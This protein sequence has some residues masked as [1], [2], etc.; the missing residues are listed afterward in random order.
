MPS[1][2]KRASSYTFVSLKRHRLEGGSPVQPFRLLR[3]ALIFLFDGSGRLELNGQPCPLEPESCWALAPG[4]WIKAELQP[5]RPLDAYVLEY[6]GSGPSVLPL[7]AAAKPR[8]GAPELPGRSVR[9]AAPSSVLTLLGGMLELGRSRTPSAFFR[10]QALL[11]E[12]LHRVSLMPGEE[13]NGAQ[14]AVQRTIRYLETHYMEPIQVGELPRMASLTPSAYCRS[15][16]KATGQSPTA[17]LTELRMRQAKEL[18][19]QPGRPTLRDIAA[20]V[21]YADELYFSRLFKKTAGV[22]PS[23][24]AG[25]SATRVAIVSHLFLQDHLLAL[26]IKPVA[27]PAFPSV[28]RTPSGFPDYLQPQL[29]GTKPLNAET[30]ILPRDVQSLSPDLIIKMDFGGNPTDGPWRGMPNTVC[31]DGFGGWQAYLESLGAMLGREAEAEAAVS[32]VQGIELAYRG[33][34]ASAAAAAGEL[35]IVRVLPGDFRLFGADGHAFS[36]LFYRALG[37]CPH[38]RIRHGFYRSHAFE[39]LLSMD[40][41]SILVVWSDARELARLRAHPAWRE[42]RAVREGRLH[43]PDSRE[44]DPWGPSGREFA[45]YDCARYFSGMPRGAARVR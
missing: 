10:R 35:A 19:R 21:G 9:I 5:D 13:E 20:S 26:G 41:D 42:L 16:K 23:A 30:S 40:P 43:V 27:A 6:D 36:D 38:S 45:I 2:T 33:Q 44:W 1:V 12:L 8:P 17:Y 15:F 24:F 14:E 28:Y 32:R 18:L 31:M 37:F 22:S 25:R 11:Y 39:E 4:T 7:C 34:L 29:E 3:H